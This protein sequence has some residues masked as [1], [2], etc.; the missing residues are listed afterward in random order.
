MDIVY[1]FCESDT[2]RIPFY[3][4]DERLFRSLLAKGGAWDKASRQFIFRDINSAGQFSQIFAGIPWVWIDE[5]EASTA[6]N[7]VIFIWFAGQR[8]SYA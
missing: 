6:F 5:K 2:V 3:K 4:Y 7:A 8:S 1:L